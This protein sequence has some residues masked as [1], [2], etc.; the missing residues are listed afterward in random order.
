LKA[1]STKTIAMKI[2][3]FILLFL[4]M[5]SLQL[6][7][8][9]VLSG[10]IRPRY[11]FRNG[12]RHLPDE[13]TW[14]AHL[15]SQRT[16][17]NLAWRSKG[18][19]SAIRFQDVRIWGDEAMKKDVAGLGLY[20][21]WVEVRVFDSLYIKAGRQELVVD[22]QR[23]FSNNNWSQKAVTHDALSIHYQRAAWRWDGAIAFNQSR[24]TTFSTD[25]AGSIGNYKALYL[26]ILS[27]KAGSFRI[28]ALSAGDSWQKKGTLNTQYL[29]L[30]HGLIFQYHGKAVQSALRGFYQSGRSESGMP[31]DAYYAA[32]DLTASS[33]KHW[34][35][36]GGAEYQSG[37]DSSRQ[38][39]SLVRYFTCLYGSGHSFNGFLDY[40]TKPSD[41]RNTGLFDAFLNIRHKGPD[42]LSI[43]LELHAF[44]NSGKYPDRIKG[45]LMSNFLA[46]EADLCLRWQAR[47]DM[48]LQAGYSFLQGSPTLAA[49]S[50]GNQAHTSHWTYLMLTFK[51]VF[52]EWS[53][54]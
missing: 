17:L 26:S 2:R 51:P 13:H 20:E 54:H 4:S 21:G 49:L 7:A 8:Q 32:I 9:L 11:E 16:R 52:L 29:R 23:L 10:E 34:Q 12:Y 6:E 18:I 36:G 38:G 50:G 37:Q 5:G 47:K 48:E 53:G 25:Y 39:A 30:T 43:T 42:P 22:N 35:F 31:V 33:G 15:V 40:F 24:D 19:S 1:Y 3:L 45:G 44:M 14:P 41:T 46:L 27:R 28:S